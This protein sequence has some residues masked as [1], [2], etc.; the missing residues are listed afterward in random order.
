MGVTVGTRTWTLGWGRFLH[1][2]RRKS[3]SEK[4]TAPPSALFDEQWYCD[5]YPDVVEAGANPLQHYL[6]HGRLEGRAATQSAWEASELSRGVF[7]RAYY[8][9]QYPDVAEAAACGLDP[10]AHYLEHGRI[11]GRAPNQAALEQAEFTAAWFDRIWYL[12]HYTDVA[13]SGQDPLT[14]YLRHGRTEGRHP[15]IAA[16]QAVELAR[17]AFDPDWYLQ[18]Y[19]DVRESGVDPVHHFLQFGREEGRLASIDHARSAAWV[20]TFGTM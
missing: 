14:H 8:V 20:R 5:R 16:W 2:V 11:E 13:T 17:T 18:R 1:F 7:D 6:E 4:P 19:P 15:N 3:G 10:L 12:D 9:E